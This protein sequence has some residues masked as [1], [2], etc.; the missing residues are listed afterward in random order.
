M[1]IN[2]SFHLPIEVK[3]IGIGSMTA[4]LQNK[5]YLINGVF[6]RCFIHVEMHRTVKDTRQ[7]SLFDAHVVANRN[8]RRDV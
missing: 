8:H 7:C 2:I 3:P 5:L 6:I 4:A 1:K